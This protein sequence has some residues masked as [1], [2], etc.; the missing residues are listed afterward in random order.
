M[1]RKQVYLGQQHQDA[2]RNLSEA[3][4]ISE[5]EVIRRAIDAQQGRQQRK[6]LLDPQAWGRA[7][8][9]MKST[10]RKNRP[11]RRV[12]HASWNREQLYEDRL[13]RHAH[14]TR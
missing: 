13:N 4:G 1:I 8:K 3:H 14:R 11:S 5:A 10:Q 9:V 7:V 2:I 6:T 12:K